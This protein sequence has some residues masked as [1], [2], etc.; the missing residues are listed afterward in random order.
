MEIALKI[1][2]PIL[3]LRDILPHVHFK[4]GYSKDVPIIHFSAYVYNIYK[5]VDEWYSP[6]TYA[7]ATKRRVQ[8]H[9]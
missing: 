3:T 1:F 9:I 5:I 2:D 7:Y 4:I 8:V 6:H